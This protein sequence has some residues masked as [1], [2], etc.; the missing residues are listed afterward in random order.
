MRSIE[1]PARPGATPR[2]RI[3]LGAVSAIAARTA[4]GV[5]SAETGSIRPAISAPPISGGV[6]LG[7]DLLAGIPLGVGVA[8]EAGQEDGHRDASG[9]VRRRTRSRFSLP[10]A[11][12]SASP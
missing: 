4:P 10:I 2:Q 7:D 3:R 9:S 5:R 1:R 12:R 8:R 11:R 6:E